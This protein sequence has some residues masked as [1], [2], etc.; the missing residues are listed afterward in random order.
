MDRILD[1]RLQGERVFVVIDVEGAEKLVLEGA[2]KMFVN[3]PKPIWLVEITATEHQPSGVGVNPNFK[4]IFQFFIQNGYQAF[5]V[6][7]NIEIVTAKAC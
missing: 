2:A 6:D 1:S 4:E 5:V 3:N 7:K